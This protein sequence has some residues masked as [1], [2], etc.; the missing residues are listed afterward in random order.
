MLFR[1]VVGVGATAVL[2]VAASAKIGASEIYYLPLSYLLALG[3][4]V[5][6]AILR[7]EAAGTQR[8]RVLPAVLWTSAFGWGA[9]LAAVATVFL[10]FQGV[11]SVTPQHARNLEV[12]RCIEALP[13][14][15]FVDDLYLSLP[16]MNV[17]GPH[18]VVSYNYETDRRAGLAFE[19]GGIG[20]M[21]EN[22][23]FA[24]LVLRD[25]DETLDG[26][27]LDRYERRPGSCGHFVAYR[28]R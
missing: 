1:S 14:P 2:T 8:T 23:E 10:G 20:G 25:G 6:T 5:G 15:V 24:A 27:H 4:L 7:A 12:G 22:G 17:G 11:L 21:V 26:G 18:F 16:W 13:K 28:R 19:R 9:N 3:V